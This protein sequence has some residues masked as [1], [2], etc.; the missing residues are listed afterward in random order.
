MYEVLETI[1]HLYLNEKQI[2]AIAGLLPTVTIL[3]RDTF[4]KALLAYAGNI[5]VPFRGR[6]FLN[7]VYAIR[8]SDINGVTMADYLLTTNSGFSKKRPSSF[9][10]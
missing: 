2:I 7:Y 6:L 4:E 3:E 8:A 10:I 1:R 9:T 5:Y